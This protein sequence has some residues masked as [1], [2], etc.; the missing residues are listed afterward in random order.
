MKSSS[1]DNSGL[2]NRLV[3]CL[4]LVN[5]IGQ[6]KA[7]AQLWK[8]FLLE[9]RYRYESSIQIPELSQPDL[10]KFSNQ[11]QSFIP[12]DLSRCLLHQK[13]QMLNCCI[14]KKIER[15]N[16]ESTV[17]KEVKFE[18]KDD[19]AEEDDDDQFFDCEDEAAL[20][21]QESNK[22]A[23]KVPEGRLKKFGD[24]TLIKN[25]NESL[26]VPY[27]QVCFSN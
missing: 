15:L 8:E 24:L 6:T 1:T 11:E 26:Y 5:Q 4:G 3:I 25:P 10:N 9:L 21:E 14:K 20:I 19:S 22:N 13:I 12:P 16:F 18:K 27:T 23:T 17:V 7:I 2:L